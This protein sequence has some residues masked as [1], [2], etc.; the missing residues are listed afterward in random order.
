MARRKEGLSKVTLRLSDG[1]IEKLQQFYPSLTYNRV[2]RLLVDKHIQLNEQKLAER[3]GG[4][5][6]LAAPVEIPSFEEV[7]EKVQ[8]N[9]GESE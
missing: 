8:Q 2:I 5:T 9:P 6:P 3:L 1:A 7:M 4:Q